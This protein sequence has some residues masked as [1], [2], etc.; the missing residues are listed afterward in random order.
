MKKNIYLTTVR[1]LPILA[2]M[3]NCHAA[4]QIVNIDFN[5][6]RGADP[7]PT[8]FIGAGAVSNGGGTFFNGLLADSQSSDALTVGGSNLLDEFNTLTT[9]GFTIGPVGGDT[10]TGDNL[11]KDYIFVN[12]GGATTDATFTISGLGA[13]TA[14]LYFQIGFISP[15]GGA[16]AG[17][18][19]TGSTGTPGFSGN[20]H[21]WLFFDDVPI[22]AGSITGTLGNPA[23]NPGPDQGDVVTL[24]GMTIVTVP[25]PASAGLLAM[26]ALGLL[27][28]RRAGRSLPPSP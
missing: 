13:G 21:S 22:T 12:S 24:T 10:F 19:I 3:A 17:V 27:A 4:T 7:V 28:R 16:G 8:T 5:G 1:F 2:V 20:G 26:G 25:E 9:V 18:F 15:G 23:F 14:D 6:R 11:T